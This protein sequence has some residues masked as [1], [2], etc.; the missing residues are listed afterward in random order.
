MSEMSGES[1]PVDSGAVESSD[2][3]ESM[4][5]ST[6]Y[7]EADSSLSINTDQPIK[8]NPA[9]QP[10]LDALPTSLHEVISPT[11]KEWD[12]G[13]NERFREIHTQYEPYKEY[14]AILDAGIPMDDIATAMSLMQQIQD[15]PKS[16]WDTMNDY[17]KFQEAIQQETPQNTD[18]E[19]LGYVDP[20]EQKLTELEN[21]VQQ[22]TDL[23]TS[24]REQAQLSEQEMVLD[25][26]L[27]DLE[28]EYG[29]YDQE[30]VLTQ[31]AAGADPETAVQAY[32]SLVDRIKT[33][34]NRPQA[35]TVV[36]GGLGGVVAPLEIKDMSA[37][38]RRGLV[39]DMLRAAKDI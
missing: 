4:D 22:L 9:W 32:L 26:V 5:T 18:E 3:T 35:P 27:E 6:D 10:I 16:V 19:Y 17:Y 13:V 11:L 38:D 39:A 12:K 33:E 20:N 28:Q 34:S 7:S 25:S 31:M 8:T 29:P 2:F 36:G 23:I 24:E 15:D 30:F 37:Q 14:Q 21:T 1:T